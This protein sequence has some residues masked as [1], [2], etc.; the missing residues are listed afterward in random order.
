MEGDVLLT[1]ETHRT[2]Y[3]SGLVHGEKRWIAEMANHA[4]ANGAGADSDS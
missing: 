4:R 3:G 1:K 2:T